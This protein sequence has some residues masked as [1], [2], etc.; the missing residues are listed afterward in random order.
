VNGT[1]L[2]WCVVDRDG[3]ATRVE[4]IKPLDPELDRVSLE[5]LKQ[6]RFGPGHKGGTAVLVQIEVMMAFTMTNTKKSFWSG[7]TALLTP[8]IRFCPQADAPLTLAPLG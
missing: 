1:V 6:W 4:I 8:S 7:E 3:A 2:L 5:T